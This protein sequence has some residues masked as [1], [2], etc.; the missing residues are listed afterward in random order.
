MNK[1]QN[2]ESRNVLPLPKTYREEPILMVFGIA[3]FTKSIV[4]FQFS[5]VTENSKEHYT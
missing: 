3:N 5:F 4:P 2:K 1:I